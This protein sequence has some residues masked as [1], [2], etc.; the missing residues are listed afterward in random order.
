[1]IQF[2]FSQVAEPALLGQLTLI[3]QALQ[4]QEL[5]THGQGLLE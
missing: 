1:M 4:F 3:E 5:Q 2:N